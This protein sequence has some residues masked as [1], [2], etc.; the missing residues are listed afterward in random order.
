MA[1]KLPKFPKFIEGMTLNFKEVDESDAEFIFELRTDPELNEHIS[2][3]SGNIKDQIEFIK[4][5]KEKPDEYYVVFQDKKGKPYGLGRMYNITN[6]R[7]T[8]GSWIMKKS[9]PP[10]FSIESVLLMYDF[11]FKTLSLKYADIDVRKENK[12]VIAFHQRFG[13]EYVKEDELH[14]YMVLTRETYF[15]ARQRYQNFLKD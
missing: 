4:K 2:T 14:I 3:V 8:P 7:F 10:I 6:E 9:A 15:K 12:T 11:A 1:N 5:Y 13:A